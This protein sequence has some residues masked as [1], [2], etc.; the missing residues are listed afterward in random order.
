MGVF[1]GFTLLK[2]TFLVYGSRTLMRWS[3]GEAGRV[4]E[5]SC[6]MGSK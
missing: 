3:S 5:D 4:V 6:W 1:Q 2:A